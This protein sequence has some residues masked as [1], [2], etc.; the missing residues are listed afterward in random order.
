MPIVWSARRLGRS[1]RLIKA[2]ATSGRI[3]GQGL[4]TSSRG[5]STVVIRR[6]KESAVRRQGLVNCARHLVTFLR[7]PT[8]AKN[9]RSLRE[10]PKQDL[11]VHTKSGRSKR[12]VVLERRGQ[13]RDGGRH[14]RALRLVASQERHQPIC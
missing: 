4:S 1:E 14:K 9:G 13:I 10:R 8:V 11:A 5:R 12:A 2:A 6:Q 3:S 7:G